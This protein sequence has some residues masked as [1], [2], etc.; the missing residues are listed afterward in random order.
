MKHVFHKKNHIFC[1]EL[2]PN[3]QIFRLQ[4]FG[5][6][7]LEFY[8]GQNKVIQLEAKSIHRKILDR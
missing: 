8:Q 2:E 1:T 5:L 7:S 4:L 3:F 6:S